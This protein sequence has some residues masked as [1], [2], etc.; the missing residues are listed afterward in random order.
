MTE[1]TSTNTT[2][3][4][5]S[6]LP[7]DC[8]ELYDDPEELAEMERLERMHL[9]AQEEMEHQESHDGSNLPPEEYDGFFIPVD[10]A[11]AKT[12]MEQRED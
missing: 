3:D 12:P 8:M 7:D 4:A 11:L 6:M 2:N 9:E 10:G 1:E 5:T